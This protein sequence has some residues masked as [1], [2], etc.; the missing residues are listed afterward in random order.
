MS[1]RKNLFAAL[2]TRK[3]TL[4]TSCHKQ[5]KS[6]AGWDMVG[7]S[8]LTWLSSDCLYLPW[9]IELELEFSQKAGL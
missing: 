4:G 8:H 1:S 5:A 6:S 9:W 7:N 2:G 3:L